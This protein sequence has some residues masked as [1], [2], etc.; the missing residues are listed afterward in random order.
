[1]ELKDRIKAARKHA[2]LSQVQ[3]AS[4]AGMTQTSISDLERGKSR[5]TS[6]AT[7]IATI[8]GVSPRWLAEGRGEMLEG[9]MNRQPGN[10]DWFGGVE[11]WDDDTPLDADEIE[12]PFYKEVELSGG[13]GSTVVLQTTGRKLRFGKYSLRKKNIDAASAACVTVNGNSMEPVLPDG[14]TVGVDT[15]ARTIRDGDMY[16]FDHDGQLRVK[17][18]YRLPGGGLRVRS[19]NSDEHP[20]ERYE[21]SEAN[22]HI[23]IIGRVF[24]YSVLL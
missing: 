11:S 24:W 10:A 2:N 9:R 6:F 14:S 23:N 20:D 17:L 7:Q 15:S 16:A 22:E 8:C 21:A 4:A 19:F 5:A 18:L 12:L 3:L 13:K 1:M